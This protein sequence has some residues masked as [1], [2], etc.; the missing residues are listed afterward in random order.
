MVGFV[1]D[2]RTLYWEAAD[3]AAVFFKKCRQIC[4]ALTVCA[5]PLQILFATYFALQ[6]FSATHLLFVHVR[7]IIY[8][9]RNLRCSIFEKIQTNLQFT[10]CLCMSIADLICNVQCV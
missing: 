10:Y 7:C 2:D 8:L 3:M 5:C 9:Q 4:N 6:I 1:V